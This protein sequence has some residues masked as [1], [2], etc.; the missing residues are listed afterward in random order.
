MN[1]PLQLRPTL[2][3]AQYYTQHLCHQPTHAVVKKACHTATWEAATA[4]ATGLF[5]SDYLASTFSNGKQKHSA[6]HQMDT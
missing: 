5:L 6:K 1:S 4:T 3:L 2:C